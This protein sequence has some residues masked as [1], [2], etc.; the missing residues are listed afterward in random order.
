MGW[1]SS[2][3]TFQNERYFHCK[4]NCG[5]FVSLEKLSRYPPL[6]TLSEP[7][8]SG[9]H[10][11]NR[12]NQQAPSPPAPRSGEESNVDPQHVI[13]HRY[14]KGDRVVAFT[15]EGVPVHGVVKWVGMHSYVVN[16]KKYSCKAVGIETVT[17]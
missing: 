7:P 4:D 16:K 17:N 14:K 2:D 1:G 5:M 3:G 13:D 15:K 6:Q 11:G 8:P 12:F 9:N 10:S